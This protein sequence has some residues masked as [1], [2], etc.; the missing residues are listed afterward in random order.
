MMYCEFIERTNY[1]ESYMT[2]EMYHKHIEPIYNDS[3]LSK[4]EFCKRFRALHDTLVNKHI[5]FA[6][7]YKSTI[8]KIA[9]LN[10][11]IDF[12]DIESY[13]NKL[14]NEFMQLLQYE[15]IN[16]TLKK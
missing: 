4:N 10:G 3:E 7:S 5:E 8:E 11:E 13:H 6:L 15:A 1:G 12:N 2:C 16:Y 9:Y 14:L